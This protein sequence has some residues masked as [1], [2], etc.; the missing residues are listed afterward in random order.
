MVEQH[1]LSIKVVFLLP[2]NKTKI[3][4]IDKEKKIT[5]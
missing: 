5:K 3:I 1:N 4:Y 2:P